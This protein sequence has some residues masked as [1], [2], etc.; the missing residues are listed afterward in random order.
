MRSSWRSFIRPEN[1][2]TPYRG[3]RVLLHLARA[4]RLGRNYAVELKQVER[5]AVAKARLKQLFQAVEDLVA[6]ASRQ[7]SH[8]KQHTEARSLAELFEASKP[9]FKDRP[10]PDARPHEISGL[11]SGW[12]L[13]T[14]ARA[15]E[16][17]SEPRRQ[18][19]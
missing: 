6:I 15:V 19:A 17:A 11:E 12:N 4:R 1:A 8:V 16:H 3:G 5:N 14:G 10:K 9:T 13:K 7:F 18:T 2:I